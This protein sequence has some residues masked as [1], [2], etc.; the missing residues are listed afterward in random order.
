MTNPVFIKE[1]HNFTCLDMTKVVIFVNYRLFVLIIKTFL[2]TNF[3]KFHH[4]SKAYVQNVGKVMT[5]VIFLGVSYGNLFISYTIV[6][7]S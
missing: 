6:I 4:V 1:D 2:S 5:N 7:K 3:V